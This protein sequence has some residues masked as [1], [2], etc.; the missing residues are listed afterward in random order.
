MLFEKEPLYIFLHMYKCGGTTIKNHLEKN[1][2]KDEVLR[3]YGNQPP[4]LRNQDMITGY[5]Q[6]LSEQQRD[7]LKVL[8]GH[9]VF[10]GIHEFFPGREPRYITFLRDPVR[11]VVS[12]YNF[13]RG[14]LANKLGSAMTYRRLHKQFMKSGAIRGFHE[15]LNLNTQ[16]H[17]RIVQV[18][19]RFFS[20]QN[21]SGI[22]LEE[23]HKRL[24]DFYFIGFTETPEDFLLV[25]H[26]LGITEYVADANISKKYFDRPNLVRDREKILS[27][28]L[29]DRQICEHALDI[30]RAFKENNPW[31][32]KAVAEKGA[33]KQRYLKQKTPVNLLTKI[34]R[35][36]YEISLYL[37]RR[38]KL[39]QTVISTVKRENNKRPLY[40]FLHVMKCAG[41]T[42]SRHLTENLE[43]DKVLL[44]YER[45]NPDCQDRASIRNK[46]LT[47]P[48]AARDNIRIIFG[49]N[50]YYG[51]HKFFPD[52]EARYVTFLREPLDR[53]FSH[54]N[55]EVTM[56]DKEINLRRHRLFLFRGGKFL[57]MK[58]WFEHN[59]IFRN[60][61]FKF[62]FTR[63]FSE[64]SFCI[65]DWYAVS[66]REV[67]EQNLQRVKRKLKKFYF[68]GLVEDSRD[69]LFIYH[70][71]GFGRF[72]DRDNVSTR[73]VRGE[74]AA[75]LKNIL[76]EGLQADAELYR[77]TQRLN[78][79]FKARYPSYYAAVS[80]CWLKKNYLAL[81]DVV[82]P[83]LY[84][85]SLRIR[86]R[87]RL[88]A[89]CLDAFKSMF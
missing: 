18:M 19:S 1:F 77:F 62:L 73:F 9:R 60:Y 85:V 56:L 79:R 59:G 51:I 65:D 29:G 87:S 76:R 55:F 72:L 44:L 27:K 78:K 3:F 42:I 53:T 66:D 39:Y 35:S 15:W 21:P 48:R 68:V 38:S 37:R 26:L 23:I 63:M 86:M 31:F 81:K 40:I 67:T 12:H 32:D 80:C 41:T 17:N 13:G 69:F 82:V 58:E 46:I 5:L 4:Y 11:R 54:Y 52:R 83:F 34:T 57:S 88:Y 33:E 49:H 28:N 16:F 84:R 2:G 61:I 75:G 30:N 14:N 89:K 70:K 45:S 22:S 6:T 74:E 71:L 47:L 43:T 10:W 25:Y 20:P 64:K 36:L 50:V 24:E 7:T 8:I